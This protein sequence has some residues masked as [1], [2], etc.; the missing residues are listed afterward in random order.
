[1]FN[2]WNNNFS[3]VKV[4]NE[5][6]SNIN[7][8]KSTYQNSPII[9][10]KYNKSMPSLTTTLNDDRNDRNYLKKEEYSNLSSQNNSNS[11]NESSKFNSMKIKS[12]A[13]LACSGKL[14]YDS[15]KSFESNDI[16]NSNQ[17]YD[18]EDSNFSLTKKPGGSINLNKKRH[19]TSK[20]SKGDSKLK[21]RSSTFGKKILTLIN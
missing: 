14:S 3:N 10:K 7:L 19:L 18:Y 1:L 16:E 5:F 2:L 13:K 9:D 6:G 21:S 20:A 8:A 12:K 15:K 11:I 17:E 4:K